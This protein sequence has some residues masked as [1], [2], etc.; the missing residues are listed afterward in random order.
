MLTVLLAG[1]L[2]VLGVVAVLAYVSNAE[3]RAVEKLSP[4]RVLVAKDSIPTGT[5]TEAAFRNH[6]LVYEQLPEK[7]VPADALRSISYANSKL[8]TGSPLAPGELLVQSMLVAKSQGATPLAIPAGKE[9]ISIAVCLAGDVAG[10]VQPG[11]KVA[12]YN[13]GGSQAPLQYSCASHQPPSKGGVV[14]QVVLSNV[15]VLSVI[16]NPTPSQTSSSTSSAPVSGTAGSASTSVISQGLVLVT[17]VVAV[18][19]APKLIS[20]S[21]SGELTLALLTPTTQVSVTGSTSSP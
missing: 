18:S 11:A 8:V 14:T 4:I 7:T 3:Q 10:Y 5:N 13:S 12:I 6:L 2:A 17:V 21:T 19:E 16:P 9:A 20:A 15:E 1:A